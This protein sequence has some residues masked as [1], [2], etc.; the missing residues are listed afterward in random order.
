V[1]H[2]GVFSGATLP[3]LHG[4]RVVLRWLTPHDVPALFAVFSDREVMRYW[5]SPAMCDPAE[6]EALLAEIHASYAARTLFQWGIASRADDRVIGTCTL[7]RI[8]DKNRRAEIGYALGR[9]Y[10]GRGLARESLAVLLRYAFDHLAL[11]RIEADVDP[12]NAASLRLLEGLGFAREG[13]LRE[14]WR[15]AGGVQDSVILGLLR[16]EFAG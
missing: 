14:R 6:A 3:E 1:A 15:V 13:Y 8:D 11:E 16:R 9:D 5:S 7:Y 10:W 4:E 12:D 2:W